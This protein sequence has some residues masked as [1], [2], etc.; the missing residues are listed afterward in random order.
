MIL[1]D[2]PWI[3]T[4]LVLLMKIFYLP[5]F[6]SDILAYLLP[7]YCYQLLI[8]DVIRVVK[9]VHLYWLVNRDQKDRLTAATYAAPAELL[10]HTLPCLP[11]VFH[12]LE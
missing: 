5:V 3:S 1:Q 11:V 8:H 4:N 9:T 6:G 7:N 10:Y 12:T 2:F